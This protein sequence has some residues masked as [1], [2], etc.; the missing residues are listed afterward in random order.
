[1]E[2]VFQISKILKIGLGSTGLFLPML[3]SM[4]LLISSYFTTFPGGRPGGRAAGELENK[5]NSVQFQLKLQA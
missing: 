3:Q 1:M 5:T 2:V 4:F